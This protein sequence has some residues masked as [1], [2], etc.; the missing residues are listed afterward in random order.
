MRGF[1]ATV[2]TVGAAICLATPSMAVAHTINICWHEEANGSTTFYARH[3]HSG[4]PLGGALLIDGVRYPFTQSRLGRPPVMDACQP[5]GCNTAAVA[6][7]YFAVNVPHVGGGAHQ[8]GVSCDSDTICGFPGCYPTAVTFN[9][10]CDDFD[11]D[12]VCDED[13]NCAEAANG[14]QDDSDGDGAGDACD[15]CPDDATDDV[16]FDGICGN[17]DNCPEVANADQADADEDGFGDACD[18]CPLDPD[19][20]ADLDG[21]CGNED[22]CPDVANG[23]Q[24]DADDDGSGDA[25]DACSLDPDDDADGD[26]VCGDVDACPETVLPDPVPT[27]SLGVNRFADVNGDGK[28]ETVPP[29]RRAPKRAFTIVETAG[30]SCAQIITELELG[31]GHRKYG[32]TVDTMTEWIATVAP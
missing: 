26:G 32:C 29:G 28:F 5:V 10:S 22:N 20:D 4:Q 19:D 17:D 12:G 8:I 24:A 2:V 3:Y 6:N 13:D 23:D 21:S 18:V 1:R 11:A 9:S 15:V 25:C 27:I 31:K 14:D 16:D 30:C 7:A